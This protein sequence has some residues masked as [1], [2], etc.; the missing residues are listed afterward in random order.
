MYSSD[1][2]RDEGIASCKENGPKGVTQDD[3]KK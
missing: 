2:A 1:A 3:S